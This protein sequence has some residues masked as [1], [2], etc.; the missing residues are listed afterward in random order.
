V[1]VVLRNLASRAGVVFVGQVMRIEH[2]TGTV[3][4]V[5]QVQQPVLGSAGATYTLREWGGLWAAGQQ[6]YRL[7]ERAMVFL[8][9]PGNSANG[10]GLGS[11]VDGMDG[12]VP[13][14]VQGA[15]AAALLDVRRLAARVLRAQGAPIADAERGAISVTDGATVAAGWK[16][17]ETPEPV[18]RPL[19]V[20]VRP[21]QPVTGVGPVQAADARQGNG[22]HDTVQAARGGL[23]ANR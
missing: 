4:I 10:S 11:P 2:K 23:D 19:P 1:G 9:G 15:N 5:F 12:V 16:N 18:R 22:A 17:V 7:G 20:G 6:R 13:V 14:V 3:E 8:R 21:A